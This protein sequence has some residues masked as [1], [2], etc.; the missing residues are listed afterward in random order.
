MKS[1]GTPPPGS[2]ELRRL[3][4]LGRSDVEGPSDDELIAL[5]EGRI[6]AEERERLVDRLTDSPDAAARYRVLQD[7]HA[8]AQALEAKQR[9][10][11]RYWPAAAAVV[12]A[13]T[14]S[15]LF[16]PAPIEEPRVRGF[17]TDAAPAGL[18]E[19]NAAPAELTWPTGSVTPPYQL[20]L[21]DENASLL[22]SESTSATGRLPLP[23]SAH[24]VMP[25]GTYFWTVTDSRGRELGPYWFR[26]LQ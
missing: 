19:L 20:E 18:I 22:W 5:I 11:T 4:A 25:A 17:V 8:N 9:S 15:L 21:Y 23:A 3:Y 14:A 7:V 24:E 2:D 16:L 1:D 13:L 12:I 26:V 6:S 10:L